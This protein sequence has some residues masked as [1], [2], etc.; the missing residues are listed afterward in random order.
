MAQQG[1]NIFS[2]EDEKMAAFLKERNLDHANRVSAEVHPRNTLYT[3]FGKRALDLIIITPVILV[4][5]PVYL[6]L[7]LLN[8]IDMG[9]PILYKQTRYGYRGR[10]YNMLKFR[11]MKNITDSEGRQLPPSQ[12]LTKYGRFIRKFSLDELPNMF[13]IFMGEMS[14]IGP[15][16]VPI[17]Y[18]ERMSERHKMMSAVRPGLE[19]PRM[20]N[21]ESDDEISNYHISFEN[22]IWYVENISFATDVRM[23]FAL[24]KMVFSMKERSRN[25]GGASYFAGYDD[26]GRAISTKLAD[27][28]YG[29]QIAE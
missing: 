12:R 16:A 13:N 22:S 9:K 21:I 2:K 3:R 29:D 4:L 27:K 6:V 1:N 17:F 11:S 23:V 14:I 25:A 5:S 20:I 18:M 8:L 10:H 19:C 15:R 28:L 26:K 24:V 7:A